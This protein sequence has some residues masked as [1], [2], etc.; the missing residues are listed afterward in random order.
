MPAKIINI[1]L[2]NMFITSTNISKLYS[3]YQ[4]YNTQ[5]FNS[6]TR[7]YRNTAFVPDDTLRLTARRD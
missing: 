2:C 6:N 5:D 1:R 7:L 4:P 3:K